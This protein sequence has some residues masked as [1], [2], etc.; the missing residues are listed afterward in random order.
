MFA[1]QRVIAL[2]L[3]AFFA[4]PVGAR[5][6]PKAAA[7]AA[8]PAT[9]G[10]AVDESNFRSLFSRSAREMD[11]S[12]AREASPFHLEFGASYL[13]WSAL[14]L[15]NAFFSVDYASQMG[16]LPSVQISASKKFDARGF[17]VEPFVAVG[18]GMREALV[19]VVSAQSAVLKDFVSVHALPLAAGV[20]VSHPLRAAPAVTAFLAPSLGAQFFYQSGAL[21]GMDQGYWIPN[22]ALR[23][24]LSLFET[25]ASSRAP[26]A[27]LDG[28]TLSGAIHR[29]LSA[30]APLRAWSIEL[31]LRV[32]L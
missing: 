31:G 24:G 5:E 32:L 3:G 17:G 8:A 1:R 14:E 30:S 26:D 29:G 18:Y 6:K 28:I 22:L 27:W 19:D 2:G 4:L 10:I 13:S 16:A 7:P 25:A 12:L 9:P 23:G 21:D 20:R 15:S 11:A